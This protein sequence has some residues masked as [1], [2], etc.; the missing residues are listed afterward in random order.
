MDMFK[1]M[2][3]LK[4]LKSLQKDIESTTISESC[5]GIEIEITGSGNVKNLSISEDAYNK[6]KISLEKALQNAVSL[7]SK[8]LQ[9]LQKEKAKEA[10]GGIN[11]PGLMD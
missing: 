2:K 1:M 8:K 6:G 11:I 9:D 10:L 3:Q 7:C 5:D 4:N